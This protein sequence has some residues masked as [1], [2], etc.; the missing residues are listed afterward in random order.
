[1]L[2]AADSTEELVEGL[3]L[4]A[5]DYLAKPVVLAELGARLRALM[6]RAASPRQSVLVR[7]DLVLDSGA[8]SVSRAGRPLRLTG[9]EFDLLESLLR[10][11]GRVLS[12]NALRRRPRADGDD[13]QQRAIA[14][15]RKCGY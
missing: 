3:D 10:A 1:M 12:S 6:R 11:D 13:A 8:R 14:L 5:D 15:Y 4:G 2:T 7:G 9:R